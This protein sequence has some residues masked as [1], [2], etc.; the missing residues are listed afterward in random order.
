MKK[1]IIYT[2]VILM[3]SFIITSCTGDLDLI[4][5][6]SESSAKVYNDADNYVNV[7]AKIYGG[8]VLSGNEGPAG[9]PDI[10]DIDEGFSPY[11]RVY[12]NLQELPTDE[13]VCGWNDT[14]IPELNTMTWGSSNSFVKAMYS[15]LFFQITLCNE[16]IRESSQENMDRRGFSAEDQTRIAGYRAEARFL[17]ALSWYHALDLFGNVPFMTEEDGIG[18]FTPEQTNRNDL[19]AYVE[20]ELLA[21]ETDLLAPK[22]NEY[23][24]VDKAAASFYWHSCT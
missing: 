5:K 1:R 3:S 23:A 15:R 20:S 13:A 6:Y 19:F 2:A 24:R 22:T 9:N 18:S 7:L 17:R 12:W 16:F 4:P 10:A 8:L 11:L 21:I 14:G